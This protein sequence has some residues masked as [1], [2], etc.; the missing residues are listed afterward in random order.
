MNLERTLGGDRR[1]R[2]R[3]ES[4]QL[5][6]LRALAHRHE[7]FGGGRMNR[8]GAI[9]IALGPGGQSG[10]VVVLAWSGAGGKRLR[11]ACG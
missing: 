1:A 4:G 11:G 8:D 3:G 10:D 7:L 6:W 9:E 2:A 5:S